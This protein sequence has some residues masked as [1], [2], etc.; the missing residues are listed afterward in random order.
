MVPLSL[1]KINLEM[2]MVILLIS[3]KLRDQVWKW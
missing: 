2:Y 3:E 1:S